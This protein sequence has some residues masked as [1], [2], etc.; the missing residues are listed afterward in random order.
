[1]AKMV[2]QQDKREGV[3]VI[4]ERKAIQKVSITFHETSI[5]LLGKITMR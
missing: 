1:M 2:S 5:F 4:K 3:N